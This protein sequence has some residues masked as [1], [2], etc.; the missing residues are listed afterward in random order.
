MET[1]RRERV[2]LCEGNVSSY[3]HKNRVRNM[4]EVKG[5]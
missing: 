2:N 5:Y 1:D 4:K 3:L